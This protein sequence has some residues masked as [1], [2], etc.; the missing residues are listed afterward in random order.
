MA[1]ISEDRQLFCAGALVG[2]LSGDGKSKDLT[3]DEPVKTVSGP[4]LAHSW[5]SMSKANTSAYIYVCVCVCHYYDIYTHPKR[6]ECC[7]PVA[8]HH[9]LCCPPHNIKLPLLRVVHKK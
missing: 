6:V 2:V 5:F 1:A 3:S 4:I 9:F 7:S 8:K